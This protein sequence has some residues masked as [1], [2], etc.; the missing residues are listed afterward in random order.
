MKFGRLSKVAL[1][2]CVAF[3]LAACDT[4]EE[5]AE[6]HF[7][8]GVSLLE[9]GDVDRAI[10]EFRNVLSLNEFHREAR[11]LYAQAVKEKGNL[12]EAYAQFLRLSEEDPNDMESRVELT[13]MAISAQNWEEAERHSEALL[14]ANAEVEGVD[15][16]EAVMRYRQAVLDDDDAARAAAIADVKRLAEEHPEDTNLL[17]ILIESYAR[18]GDLDSVLETIDRTIAVAPDN[19]DFYRMKAAALAELQDFSALEDHLREMLD[20]FPDATGIGASLVRLLVASGQLERA[21]DFLRAELARS[22][23][24]LDMHAGLIAFLREV[25]GDDAALA[26]IEAAL[27]SYEDGAVLRA[28]RAGILFDQGRRDDAIEE[29]ESAIEGR[30]PSARVDN[31]KIGLARMLE[32]TGNEVGARALVGEVL[33]SDPS[34]VEA[35]KM[36]AAWLIQSDETDEAISTL[37]TALDQEPQDTETMSLLADAHERAGEFEIAQDILALAAESSG[38][39]PR[40]SLRFARVLLGNERYRPAE[41]VLVN[42]LRRTPGDLGLLGL[43]ADVYLATEDWPRLQD[44]EN[45]LRREGSPEAVSTANTLRLQVLARTQGQEQAQEYL[46]RLVEDESLGDA[47]RLTLL[48]TRINSGDADGAIALARELA[49]DNDNNPRARLLVANTMLGLRRYADAES[50]IRAILEETPT[51]EP[52]WIQLVRALAAQGN[53]EEARETVDEALAASPNSINMLWVKASFLE[54]SNDIDAAIEIYE[55][56]YERASD[57][58]VIA[59]NLA[60]LLITYR[61]DEESIARAATIGRRLRGTEVPP[62]QDTYGWILYRQGNF[63]EAIT[64][65]EPAAAAIPNDPLVQYH[66]AAAYQAVG[67]EQ[68]ALA[69]YRRVVEI[70]GADDPRDQIRKALDEIEALEANGVTE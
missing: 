27:P 5:R 3:V 55:E 63:E 58:P 56:L 54:Q 66:L 60:S 21:E 9:A 47:P 61:D 25:K 70:A 53:R 69:Q 33:E 40:E 43:L 42:A 37:R 35:L 68:R 57:S 48:A 46:E 36:R 44:V 64:Y 24:P 39:A 13:R 59:N 17:R 1:I 41:D 31:L 65:L 6:K 26:E 34:Q 52:G 11:A 19:I 16:V 22:D 38:F 29:M 7:E 18:D 23:V 8:S 62:F 28:L 51:F 20:R 45:A 49:A 30:E 2:G 32:A 50:E 12:T 15:A 67:Q 10:V 4:A 14:N